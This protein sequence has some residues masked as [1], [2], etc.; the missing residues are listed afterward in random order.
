MSFPFHSFHAPPPASPSSLHLPTSHLVFS[1]HPLLFLTHFLIISNHLS[2]LSF[3]NYLLV[4]C[5]SVCMLHP[6]FFVH[7]Q[8]TLVFTCF[9]TTLQKLL[10]MPLLNQYS[11]TIFLLLFTSWSRFEQELN[12]KFICTALKHIHSLRWFH[13]AHVTKHWVKALKWKVI[14]A[15]VKDFIIYFLFK[16]L[17]WSLAFLLLFNYPGS[18]LTYIS[19]YWPLYLLYVCTPPLSWTLVKSLLFLCV[20]GYKY[21]YTGNLS[22]QVRC[23]CWD[24]VMSQSSG[25]SV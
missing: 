16:S 7:Q 17:T 25:S 24:E 8:W 18:I 5:I 13:T 10:Q 3:H 2:I 23:T 4:I 19:F 1:N 12:V 15:K 20:G 11:S 6:F 9:S 21:L 14:P 22:R